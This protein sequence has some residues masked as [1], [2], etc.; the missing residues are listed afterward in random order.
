MAAGSLTLQ[1]VGCC[2]LA[3]GRVQEG[4]GGREQGRGVVGGDRRL[5]RAF[6][7]F[8]PFLSNGGEIRLCCATRRYAGT[9]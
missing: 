2:A 6:L 4:D 8:R 9:A 3:A 1:H 5:V 7:L